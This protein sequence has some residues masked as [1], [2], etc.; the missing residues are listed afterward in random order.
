MTS[1]FEIPFQERE[2]VL[3]VL[4][5]FGHQLLEAA[6]ERE[7]DML[8]EGAEQFVFRNPD[9]IGFKTISPDMLQLFIEANAPAYNFSPVLQGWRDTDGL[10]ESAHLWWRWASSH[11]EVFGQI[12]G[13]QTEGGD[14]PALQCK[15][16]MGRLTEDI[17]ATAADMQLGALDGFGNFKSGISF[18]FDAD[19]LNTPTESRATEQLGYIVNEMRSIFTYAESIEGNGISVYRYPIVS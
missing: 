7:D 4:N 18:A 14:Q 6:T 1:S 10:V 9:G 13:L 11:Y 12:R 17:Y 19:S 5:D 8:A 2:P 3:I 16:I 15:V